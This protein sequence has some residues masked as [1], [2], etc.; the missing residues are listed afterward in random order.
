[1]HN[2]KGTLVYQSIKKFCATH[3]NGSVAM[4]DGAAEEAPLPGAT[5]L[6]ISGSGPQRVES[7]DHRGQ[8]LL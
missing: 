8:F 3:N 1:M 2:A 5:R 7:R 6:V 4:P